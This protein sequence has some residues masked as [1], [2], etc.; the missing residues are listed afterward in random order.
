[1][2]VGKITKSSV[3]A[4]KPAAVDQYLLGSSGFRVGRKTP[5]LVRRGGR[6]ARAALRG[7]K[8]GQGGR[9]GPR[10]TRIL[11]VPPEGGT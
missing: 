1:M 9:R 11:L 10:W 7:V 5:G 8:A 4:M 3:E 2:P 6:P